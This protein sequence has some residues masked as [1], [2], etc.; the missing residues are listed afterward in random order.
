LLGAAAAREEVVQNGNA[1][2]VAIRNIKDVFAIR[3]VCLVPIKAL[4]AA[5]ER[6]TFMLIHLVCNF[7]FRSLTVGE[8][9]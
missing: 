3:L 6:R 1:K 8:K 7:D 2:S 9:S 5:C 4:R